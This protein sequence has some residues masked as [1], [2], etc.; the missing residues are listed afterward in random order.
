[1]QQ[2]CFGWAHGSFDEQAAQSGEPAVPDLDFV[3]LKPS[4]AAIHHHRS[5]SAVILA[6]RA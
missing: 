4:V 3:F 5:L 6:L 1:L 2:A